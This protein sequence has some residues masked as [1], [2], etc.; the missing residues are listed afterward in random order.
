MNYDSKQVT[1]LYAEDEKEAREG[2]AKTLKRYTKEQYIADDGEKAIELYRQYHPD[3]VI[4]DIN[5]PNKNGIELAEEILEI[6]PEQIIIFTTAH[7]ESKYTLR[8]LEMQVEAYMIKPINKNKFK[9]KLNHIT[10]NII[11]ERENKKNQKIIQAMLDSQSSILVLTDFFNI[12]FASKSFLKLFNVSCKEEFSLK[13]E[14]FID[15]FKDMPSCIYEITKDNF[16][17]S[18]NNKEETI[19]CLSENKKI[20]KINIDEINID[21]SILYAIFFIDITTLH[22]QRKKALY[23]S[24]HDNLTSSYNRVM[25]DKLLD[26][27]YLR[28]IRH[29]RPLCLAIF[30]IDHFKAINDTYGHLAG[31]RILMA[32]ADFFHKNIRDIDIFARWGGEEFVL[33]MGETQIDEAQKVCEKLIKGIEEMDMKNL[34]NITMSAGATEIDKDDSKEEFFKRADDALYDAKRSG[35]N[36]VVV[37]NKF[38]VRF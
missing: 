13:Y 3:I 34:P 33:L 9:E 37:N 23:E 7:T 28:F 38:E 4:T 12:E 10:K 36:Q 26:T 27:E 21:K 17:E 1:V 24:F 16:M 29:Q 22:N 20:Y 14:N 32:L 11:S 35:R 15:I 19:V 31:D 2:F 6:N 5:M 25:F 18:Y 8:A 30:D